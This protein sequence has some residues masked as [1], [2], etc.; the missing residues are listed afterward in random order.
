MGKLVIKDKIVI[1]IAV[2]ILVGS[3]IFRFDN[4]YL[5]DKAFTIISILIIIAIPLRISINKSIIPILCCFICVFGVIAINTFYHSIVDNGSIL[6]VFLIKILALTILLGRYVNNTNLI[7]EIISKVFFVILLLNI[8]QT[9]FFPDVLGKRDGKDLYLIGS[10][11]NNFGGTYI[12]GIFSSWVLLKLDKKYRWMYW[13]QLLLSFFSVVSVGS[14]TSATAL[15]FIILYSLLQKYR[16]VQKVAPLLLLLCVFLFL[17]LVVLQNNV[18]ILSGIDLVSMFLG[19]TGK[20]LT[21]SGRLYI[22]SNALRIIDQNPVFGVGYYQ[23]G[24]WAEL[25]LSAVNAHNI[26]LDV[27]LVG[28][29]TLLCLI[30]LFVFKLFHTLRKKI[31]QEYFCGIILFSSVFFLMMQFEV[32]SYFII[33]LFV[34]LVYLSGFSKKFKTDNN[35]Y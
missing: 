28:G 12:L 19:E 16:V 22:W 33:S 21:F 2:F 25:Y 5:F 29:Y 31:Q 32:Y 30:V 23:N 35:S 10:N 7:Y 26:V 1:I 27:L 11:Y 3:N 4:L 14:I 20:E 24:E 13:A 8:L 18:T 34:L 9:S 6:V 17:C 15:F